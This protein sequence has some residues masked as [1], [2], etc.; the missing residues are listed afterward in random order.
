MLNQPSVNFCAMNSA[1]LEGIQIN[2]GYDNSLLFL[3]IYACCYL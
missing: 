1:P 3:L 2:M